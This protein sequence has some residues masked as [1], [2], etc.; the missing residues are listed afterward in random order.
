MLVVYIVLLL[1]LLYQSN[2]LIETATL[3]LDNNLRYYNSYEQPFG[4]LT[5]GTY[6]ITLSNFVSLFFFLAF[7]F[8]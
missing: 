6:E 4:Y 5:G 7:C 3:T 8:L 1:T 2:G